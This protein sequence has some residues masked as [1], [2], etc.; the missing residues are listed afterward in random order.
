MPPSELTDLLPETGLIPVAPPEVLVGIPAN[1]LRRR[2]DVRSA[3]QIAAVLSAQ[4]GVAE[5]DLYPTVHLF[6]STGFRT[7]DSFGADG[8]TKDLGDLFDSD[9]YFGFIGLN[10]SWPIFN[11][12]RIKNN[13]RI[14]DAK[15]QQAIVNYEN[16]VLR[17]AAEV[18]SGL[19]GFLR[20]REE[21]THLRESVGATQRSVELS[22]TQYREGTADFIRVLTAQTFLVAQQDRL[23]A[24]EA[25]IALNLISTYKSLGGGWEI[26]RGNEFIPDALREEMRERTDWGDIMS[27]DYSSGKDVL[28]DRPDSGATANTVDDGRGKQP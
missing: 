20:A 27:P 7:G 2:P 17:A 23:A 6:G 8:M 11:Y 16:T 28:F 19:S 10:F 24:T 21:A 18:E 3:E 14:Q 1:L 25:K 15:F 22:T 12:G 26:R 9:S 4:I 5:A 13:V